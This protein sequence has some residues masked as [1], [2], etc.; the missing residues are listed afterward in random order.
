V[1]I[2]GIKLNGLYIVS[3]VAPQALQCERDSISLWHH[4]LC[5]SFEASLQH[6]ISSKQIDCKQNKIGVCESCCLA[7]AHRLPF[8]SSS[9]TSSVPL[10]LVHC[11]VW[12]PSPFVSHSGYKYYVMFT[13]H[14]SRFSWIFFCSHKS[15]IA[16]LFTQFKYLAEN[17]QNCNIK[18]LQIDGGTEFQPIIRSH[19]AIYF[20]I[21]CPYTPQQNG[22][23]EWKHRHV[24]ELSLATMLHANIP[25]TYWPF[26]LKCNIYYKS[27]VILT[28]S[29]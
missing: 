26:F 25:H 11:D 27:L 18:T 15:E 5:H 3:T 4:H 1:L 6:L 28:S 19:P 8:N 21:S 24:L 16:S 29:F 20:Q 7:K 22:L 14:F 23:T 9:T 10:E 2:Q 12:G 17:L 13:D